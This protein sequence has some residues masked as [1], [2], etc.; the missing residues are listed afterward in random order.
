MEDTIE[1]NINGGKIIKR[2]YVDNLNINMQEQ[3]R[4]QLFKDIS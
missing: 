3:G 4:I 2:S 1:I